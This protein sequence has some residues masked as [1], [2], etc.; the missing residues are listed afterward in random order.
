MVEIRRDFIEFSPEITRPEGETL[1]R[2]DIIRAIGFQGKQKLGG[3]RDGACGYDR[4]TAFMRLP[5]CSSPQYYSLNGASRNAAKLR[6]GSF[7]SPMALAT[8]STI[9]APDWDAAGFPPLSPTIDATPKCADF[10]GN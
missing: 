5:W 9:E 10:A 8:E 2:G 4:D 3:K 6:P 1:V 7:H